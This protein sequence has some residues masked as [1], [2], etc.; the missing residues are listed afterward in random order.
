MEQARKGKAPEPAGAWVLVAAAKERKK[1]AAVVGP[2]A[3]DK[4]AA[5]VSGRDK[6]E[7][8]GRNKI[9]KYP[10][11]F[12]AAGLTGWQRAAMGQPAFAM[13]PPYAALYATVQ[14]AG[15]RGLIAVS[16]SLR[17]GSP[18]PRLHRSASRGGRETV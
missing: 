1:V 12:H 6:D 7:A 18:R 11:R 9:A 13:S 3:D 10:F 16:W 17:F 4:G 8:R 2:K 15:S 5:K 14:S